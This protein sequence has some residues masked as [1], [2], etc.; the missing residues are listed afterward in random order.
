MERKVVGYYRTSSLS[1]VGSDKD[2]R[3]RQR[4]S[5]LSFTKS[6]G[7]K[8]VE[9]FYDKGVS[10][11]LDVLNR[12]QFLSMLSF[13]EKNGIDTICFES[14]DRMSRD[15]LIMETGFHYLSNLGYKLISVSNP[16]TFIEITPTGTLIRQVLGV[17]SQFEKSNLVDKLRVSRERKSLLNKSRGYISRS[18]RGKV[19][20]RK[21]L[22]QLY[23]Q[24]EELVV[25]YRR[26]V[27]K[28]T[29]KPLSYMKISN[30]LM[31]NNDLSVSFN[32]VK[33]ILDDVKMKKREE[34]NRKR[35]KSTIPSY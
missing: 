27:D 21:F 31:T 18:G 22:T 10:G 32:S 7:M 3:K 20:G 26:V 5:V 4:H 35:R 15:L 2:S 29:R 6:N 14:S 23:P 25:S 34:R 12:P 19:E 16:D 13:C 24:L 1:N 11:T 8:L 33:R 30:L 17:I 9:E 28:R